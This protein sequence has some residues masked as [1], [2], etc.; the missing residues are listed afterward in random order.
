MIEA[1]ELTAYSHVENIEFVKLDFRKR[2]PDQEVV[3]Q[4][5][6][7]RACASNVLVFRERCLE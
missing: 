6:K 4:L 2:A 7:M 5:G 3:I 1:I